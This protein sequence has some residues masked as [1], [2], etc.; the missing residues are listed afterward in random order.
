LNASGGRLRSRGLAARVNGRLNIDGI[1]IGL[2][3]L[4]SAALEAALFAC[5]SECHGPHEGSS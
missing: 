1:G 5:V 4:A 3:A 2:I